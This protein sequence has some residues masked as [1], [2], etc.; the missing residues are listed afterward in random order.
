MAKIR[1]QPAAVT[2]ERIIDAVAEILEHNGAPSLNVS[3]VMQRAGVSR[4]A[5]YVHFSNVH[6]AVA[7]VIERIANELDD[8]AADWFVDPDAV[9]SR[10]VVYQNALRAG[11]SEKP[12]AR[13]ACAI[14]D[15]T[16]MNE[17]LRSLWRHGLIQGQIDA[18]AAAIRRDQAAGVVR[19]NLDPD[20]TA[21]ALTL[22]GEQLSLELFGRGDATPEQYAAILAPIWEA[23]LFGPDD[24]N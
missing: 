16:A 3:F 5:F 6:D 8:E 15:A 4:T 17:S 20:A 10:D 24:D 1:R 22:M 12:R 14:V 11:R 2:R 18:T 7:A 9:G 21:L 13:L 23:V 19:S